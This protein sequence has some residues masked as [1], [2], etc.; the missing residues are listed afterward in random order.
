MRRKLNWF[1]KT[2]TLNITSALIC[3]INF[4][5]VKWSWFTKILKINLKS[6]KKCHTL[7]L[8][9]C[10]RNIFPILLL[11]IYSIYAVIYSMLLF[12]YRLNIKKILNGKKQEE[13]CKLTCEPGRD[14]SI[15]F[16][17]C[18]TSSYKNQGIS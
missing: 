6:E 1:S 17:I 4:Q 13:L 14:F 5:V 15:L 2:P 7:L 10:H 16:S 11:I 12:P 8:Y 18:G 3:H 9:I